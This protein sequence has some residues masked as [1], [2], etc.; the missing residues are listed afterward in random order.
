M[1]TVFAFKSILTLSDFKSILTLSDFKSILTLSHFKSILTLSEPFSQMKM[2]IFNSRLRS[3]VHGPDRLEIAAFFA[4]IK[5]IRS[6]QAFAR[7]EI[8]E[9]S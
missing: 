3:T 8:R 9:A 2:H 6:T 1:A 4:K 5:L 7:S